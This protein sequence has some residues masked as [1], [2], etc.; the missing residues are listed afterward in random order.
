MAAAATKW[1]GFKVTK[2]PNDELALTNKIYVSPDDYK[3]FKNA[4]LASRLTG[5]YI[6]VKD[7]VFT[8]AEH[9]AIPKGVIGFSGIQRKCALLGLTDSLDVSAYVSADTKIFLSNVVFEID[10]MSKSKK[11]DEFKAEDLSKIIQRQ[12]DNQYMTIDQMAVIDVSG[13][14]LTLKVRKCEV[15][16]LVA[17]A[18]GDASASASE[19]V[20]ASRGI[21]TSN[22]EIQFE[23]AQGAAMKITGTGGGLPPVLRPNWNFQSMGIG[24]LDNQF[25]DI[26]RRAFAARVF[27]PDQIAKL[28]IRHVK[29]I[30]LYGP[31]GTGK[32][33]MARQ[34]G[35]M[36]NGKEPLIVN[37]PEILSKYVGESE[38]N[39]RKLFEPAEK[40]YK[41]KGEQ[42][43]LH[44]IIFDEID[45][46][47]KQRGSRNDGTGVGDTVVN[48]MLSK[49]DGVDA[50]NNILVIG[51][52]NRKDMI[53]EALLRPG[54]FEVHMEISLPDEKG[55]VQILKIHTASM[56]AN[57]SLGDDV[58]IPD[59]AARTKN[60][61]GAEIEGLVKS[62]ASF[63]LNRQIDVTDGIKVKNSHIVVMKQ[64][65]DRSLEEVRP[66]F[67]VDSDEFVNC[68]RNGIIPYGPSV[69]KILNDGSLFVQQVRNS[70]R[71]PLV[72]VLL[73]G[74]VGSGKTALAAKLATESGYP[75][76]KL[77]SPEMLVSYSETG[78]VNKIT[79]I[80][81]DSYKS[82]LSCV[83][84]DDLE[85][86]LDYVRIGPRFSNAIL[87]VLAVLL[88]KEPPTGRRL[89]IIC[90]TSNKRVLEDMELLDLFNA[91]L[92]VP[93]ISTAQEFKKVLD[94]LQPFADSDI[95]RAVAAFSTPL[96]VKKLIMA[97]EMAKQSA[98]GIERFV[99]WL[100]DSSNQ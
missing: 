29:G 88:K 74:A 16:D 70:S 7:F 80:F 50:L 71:T 76:V 17:V 32:T 86:I 58:D 92:Q 99:Q 10:Y 3:T 13:T 5:D 66:A 82:P 63:A 61:S 39:V 49:I 27:P 12:F 25:N 65:F 28:G 20:K 45:A 42:S 22:A 72:S 15:V 100:K 62:A 90:T 36:L 40:E 46:I 68:V 48:Q 8:F 98:S 23:K 94:V 77:I 35:K 53:D 91:Q 9:T 1:P 73:E 47:C 52:T 95:A 33:L 57:G 14:T 24:G 51:M 83:V 6:Q 41:E 55:R 37:G 75:F 18:K 26:F 38:A 21:L 96:A 4:V 69:D 19:P 34:I 30:L 78:K 43:D 59:L 84:V 64:D 87:Q 44:I 89:L 11:G 79:K 60:F 67:G 54:R 31:P 81:E 85:R 93:Q 2:L 56:L 97:A